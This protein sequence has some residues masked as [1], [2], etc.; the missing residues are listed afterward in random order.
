M[1]SIK[2]LQK[3]PAIDDEPNNLTQVVSPVLSAKEPDKAGETED[4]S[5]KP[6]KSKRLSLRPYEIMGMFKPKRA[7]INLPVAPVDSADDSSKWKPPIPN[8]QQVLSTEKPGSTDATSSYPFQITDLPATTDAHTSII[9]YIMPPPVNAGT[10]LQTRDITLSPINS[11]EAD[12]AADSVPLLDMKLGDPAY[13]A[14]HNRTR[15]EDNS[16]H[17][18]RHMA[19]THAKIAL[20]LAEFSFVLQK[21]T[22]AVS[23]L[24]LSGVI[25]SN[26]Q[27]L[28]T[29]F[30]PIL[31]SQD[32]Q[33]HR[34]EVESGRG[35]SCIPQESS[36][37][38]C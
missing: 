17:E 16:K 12:S 33:V 24:L 35:L 28:F 11:S 32:H 1:E 19:A 34:R 21:Q 25:S 9:E 36:Q 30:L 18:I 14:R 2:S 38:A 29:L 20:S 8:Q 27:V 26:C 10:A 6:A 5:S 4:K 7:S 22:S 31:T 3:A 23:V 37:T 13:K 15:S